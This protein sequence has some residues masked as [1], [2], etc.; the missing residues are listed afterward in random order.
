M[1]P[2][3]QRAAAPAKTFDQE[4]LLWLGDEPGEMRAA[5]AESHPRDV[6]HTVSR[7]SQVRA[8][9]DEAHARLRADAPRP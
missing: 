9:V 8:I 2:A 7:P 4:L 1:E 6:L 5:D 3:E